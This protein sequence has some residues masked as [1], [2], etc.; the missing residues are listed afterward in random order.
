MS[1]ARRSLPGVLQTISVVRFCDGRT[2]LPAEP[3]T[4]HV[5]GKRL[6]DATAV[7]A[8]EMK[9]AEFVTARERTVALLRR[10]V[11]AR[12]DDC[13]A[14][15]MHG[16]IVSHESRDARNR[17]DHMC[18]AV[19]RRRSMTA[20]NDGEVP[21]HWRGG[22]RH[23][24]RLSPADDLRRPL[25]PLP[26]LA[27]VGEHD[28]TSRHSARTCGRDAAH[29]RLWRISGAPHSLPGSEA[30]PVGAAS[31]GDSAPRRQRRQHACGGAGGSRTECLALSSACLATR[32]AP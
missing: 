27:F 9:S 11:C 32:P 6:H 23:G 20:R 30:T 29:D 16:P 26:L 3:M 14:A 7:A 24:P 10:A 31:R 17:I 1:A 5:R 12:R 22:S 4:S 19:V 28:T 8:H 18:N 25:N 15:V 13:G 21:H 2:L